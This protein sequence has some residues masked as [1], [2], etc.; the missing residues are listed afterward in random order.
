VANDAVCLDGNI[1]GHRAAFAT[2]AT[3]GLRLG[4]PD[5]E[6][7]R[8]RWPT[9]FSDR[10]CGSRRTRSSR[11]LP[12]GLRARLRDWHSAQAAW[13]PRHLAS[14]NRASNIRFA[15]DLLS[16]WRSLSSRP[17]TFPPLS[18]RVDDLRDAPHLESNRS[19][20]PQ[21][22]GGHRRQDILLF[23]PQS[24]PSARSLCA[25][26][27]VLAGSSTTAAAAAAPAA[28]LVPAPDKHG[29]GLCLSGGGYRASLFHL[30]TVRRLHELGILT[31]P[32]FR[33][34][35]SVSGGSITNA[36][37]AVTHPW[38]APGAAW[39]QKV[40]QPLRAFTE[41]NIRT[42]PFLKSF[43]PGIATI[44]GLVPHYDK[45]LNSRTL[46]S[47]PIGLNFVFC[48]TDLSFGTNF[49]FRQNTMGDWQLGHVQTPKDWPL[50][51]AVAAS[52]CFPPLFNP[53][54]MSGLGPFQDGN[55]EK[56]DPGKWRQAISD[57][58]LTDGGNYDNM[59]LEP[60]WKHHQYVLASDAGGL[61][62][63][64]SDKDLIWRIKRYQAVQ[65]TQSRYLRRRWLMAS[66]AAGFL[67]AV[68]WAVS[69]AASSYAPGSTI[70][71]SKAF[72][73]EVIAEIRTDLDSFSDPEAAVL[74]NHGYFLAEAAIKAHAAALLP[75]TAPPLIPPFPDWSPPNKSEVDIRLALKN[76]SKR[77]LLG[78]WKPR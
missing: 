70:G 57:L 11:P 73:R 71:Y 19:R 77:T 9:K 30:G 17:R 25:V 68:Y 60:V 76:S 36:Q 67:H 28:D 47:I 32:D 10:S 4:N 61:F 24:V 72:A 7:S 49:E 37:L 15:L 50:A 31:R 18:L 55:A 63:F 53:M 20:C 27:I 52:A 65:E 69:S 46:A 29:I 40:A 16:Q 2:R 64:D 43:L 12:R 14:Q 48:A 66:D 26:P 6:A 38:P 44:D 74:Q 33:T 3:T 56:T 45:F 35:S 62:D 78:R 41:K 75:T 23:D 42:L 51:K 54:K 21:W 39:E 5:V 8:L 34:I 59:G 22:P 58:R 13:A 1:R